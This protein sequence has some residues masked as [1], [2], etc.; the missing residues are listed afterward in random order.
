MQEIN[1]PGPKA[2]S[3]RSGLNRGGGNTKRVTNEL[4]IKLNA[5]RRRQG[6]LAILDRSDE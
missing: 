1:Y 2:P 5:Y 4:A 6:S 3:G